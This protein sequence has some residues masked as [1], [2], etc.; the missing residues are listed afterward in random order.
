VSELIRFEGK[1]RLNVLHGYF[2]NPAEFRKFLTKNK[3]YLV[4]VCDAEPKVKPSD[5][6]VAEEEKREQ[7]TAVIGAGV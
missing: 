7:E 1:Y 3:K 4:I 2:T 6:A 5:A